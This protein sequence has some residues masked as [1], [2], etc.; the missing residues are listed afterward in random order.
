[1]INRYRWHEVLAI[2][3]GIGLLMVFLLAPFVEAARVS[4]S[5][6]DQALPRVGIRFLVFD[7]APDPALIGGLRRLA[8]EVP[9][10]WI[11]ELP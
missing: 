11:Y 7:E 6:L 10:I 1:M 2:Y 9:G 3:A 8:P 5:P 4:V